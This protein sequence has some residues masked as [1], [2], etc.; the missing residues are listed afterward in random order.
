M[1]LAAWLP[2]RGDRGRYEANN[3]G[4]PRLSEYYAI[5]PGTTPSTAKLPYDRAR[6]NAARGEEEE[7]ALQARVHAVV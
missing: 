1:P 6:E 7:E 3:S 5:A 4:L 2:C